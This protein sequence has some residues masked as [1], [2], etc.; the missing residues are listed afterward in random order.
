MP[1]RHR[2]TGAHPFAEALKAAER[3]MLVGMGALARAD[4]AVIWRQAREIAENYG[5]V[6]ATGTVS[7][8]C[9]PRLPGLAASILA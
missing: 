5:L 9:T 3:P 2:V 8:S 4:G 1:A 6:T 7:T